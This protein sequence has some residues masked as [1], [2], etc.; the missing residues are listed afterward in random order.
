MTNI[1]YSVILFVSLVAP[2]FQFTAP[3]RILF[4]GNSITFHPPTGIHTGMWGMAASQA[5]RDFVHRT[6]L[7]LA[8]A[9]GTVPEI[10]I[11]RYDVGWDDAAV[12]DTAKAFQPDTVVV[13][14]GDNAGTVPHD[15]YVD[16]LTALL[17]NVGDGR[18]VVLTGVWYSAERERWNGEVAQALGLT[19]VPIQDVQDAA[20]IARFDCWSTDPICSH[21]GDAGMQEIAQRIT[22]ALQPSVWRFIPW[23]TK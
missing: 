5:D 18:R 19:F 1:L 10:A 23:L 15:K 14:V 12:Y 2:S 7:Q 6:Q 20:T 16:T 13:Q 9:S 4:V 22:T 17:R 3:Q 8:A 11:A 21:P